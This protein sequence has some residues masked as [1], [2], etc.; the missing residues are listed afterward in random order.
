MPETP[1]PHADRARDD[2]ARPPATDP[3]VRSDA[4]P[5]RRRF[6]LARL[7]EAVR[8][9]DWFTVLVEVAVVVLG[10]VIG[11]QV[12][13]WGAAQ[14]DERRGRAYTERLIADLRLQ[15]QGRQY[16]VDY[17]DAVR[18]SAERA[19]ALL[20]APSADPEDLVIQAYRATEF[21]YNP[22]KREAWDEVVASGHVGLLPD[23][24]A[25]VVS[26]VFGVE[27]T[28]RVLDALQDSPYRRRV[29][30]VL[31]HAV[32]SAIRERCSDRTD[33]SGSVV[34]FVADC[35][36]GLDGA[37]LASAAQALRD[38]PA[39]REHLRYQFSDLANALN[40]L[41][42]E[43]YLID[44]AVAL[45]EGR[46]LGDFDPALLRS[47]GVDAAAPEGSG[48]SPGATTDLP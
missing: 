27:L 24:A 10:V 9:Q 22:Q 14:A 25:D 12:N 5:A 18:A 45:L 39:V 47:L 36:L 6:V 46:G 44:I 41:Q 13:A 48:P 34:G 28:D 8:R 26:F 1:P 35:G 19:V 17:F 43:A 40:Q 21:L 16:Q 4:P 42:A 32:Q 20:D 23:D 11:F 38:D 7:A 37:T 15:Q 30:S 29:R 33:E 3:D 2:H 31:P